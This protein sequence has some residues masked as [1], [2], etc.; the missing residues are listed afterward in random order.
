MARFTRNLDDTVFHVKSEDA[1][2]PYEGRIIRH[3]T[4]EH[5]GFDRTVIDTTRNIETYFANLANR[6]H[7]NTRKWVV[8]DNLFI[9]VGEPLN[10][11]RTAD[12]ERYLRDKDF[13]LDARIFVNPVRNSRDSVDV[14]V[15]TRD[16]FSLGVYVT[17][18]STTNYK[19]KIQDANFLG[20]GQRV[21]LT[22]VYDAKRKP[23][24]GSEI[25]YRKNNVGGTF[26]DA[27][28]DFTQLNTGSSLGNENE[29]ALYL[30]LNR[31][32]FMPYTRWAGGLEWS[33]NLSTNVTRKPDSTFA[34]YHYRIQDLWAGYSF[35]HQKKRKTAQENRNRK[36]FALRGFQEYFTQLPANKLTPGEQ[37]YY[38]DRKSILG[39]LTFFR[40]DFYKTR[41]VLGFGRTEDIPYGYRISLTGGLEKE[42]ERQRPYAGAEIYHN[43]VSTNG[44]FF[45]YNFKLASFYNHRRSEEGIIL[46]DITRYSRIYRLGK[47]KVRHQTEGGYSRQFNQVQKRQLDISDVNGITG[48]RADSLFGDRRLIFNTQVIV[49]TPWKL[50]GFK[51]AP[52]AR[53]DLAYLARQNEVLFQ[54]KNFIS[55]ILLGIR[56]RNENLIFNTIEARAIFYPKTV[57]G[58]NQFR[59]DFRTNIR[60]KYPTTLVF[61]P[62]TFYDPQNSF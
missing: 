26:I 41:Y 18:G 30:R 20:M 44:T 52:I 33:T 4:I 25:L 22:E 1:Y 11:Y 54:N 27:S 57:T 58:V 50:L 47:Y 48:L 61:P 43:F 16:I 21:E 10:S 40:Q 37:F 55:G 31:P 29:N 53:I 6:L 28:L 24:M 59:F 17:P 23:K 36:F 32:L 38:H 45:I 7:A 51:F 3:I 42:L 13:M 60:I 35:G 9:K 56:A 2:L 19:L 49:F 34:R 15:V 14:L 46:F 8:R 62:A 39:Q 12:N 5:I